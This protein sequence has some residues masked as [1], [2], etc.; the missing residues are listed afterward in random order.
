MFSSFLFNFLFLIFSSFAQKTE[1]FAKSWI[2]RLF[3]PTFELRILIRKV[4]KTFPRY[5]YLDGFGN[6]C[7]KYFLPSFKKFWAKNHFWRFLK[8]AVFNQKSENVYFYILYLISF[9]VMTKT[10]FTKRYKIARVAPSLRWKI[11]PFP[12][13]K[14]PIFANNHLK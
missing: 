14:I 9:E 5:V 6:F 4:R 2:C 1:I 11:F 10:I 3:C 13:A 12:I 7:Q 8:N